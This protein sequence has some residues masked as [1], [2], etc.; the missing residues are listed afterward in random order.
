[1]K[2]KSSYGLRR[3]HYD[4]LNHW[5]VALSELAIRTD[6]QD[7][8]ELLKLAQEKFEAAYKI[9]TNDHNA[10]Y[11]WA[12]SLLQQATS[13]TE[14][15]EEFFDLAVDKFKLAN[16]VNPKD[17]S[18]L[19]SW[20]DALVKRAKRSTPKEADSF[21]SL[22]M[23]KYSAAARLN[24]NNYSTYDHWGLALLEQAKRSSG[25][26]TEKLFTQAKQRFLR[27]EKITPGKG[28]YNIACVNAL[29]GNEVQAREWL[30]KS[31]RHKTIPNRQHLES[32]SDLNSI[33]DF[34]WFNE[35]L[36]Q[37]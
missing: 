33:R 31:L 16:E 1:M 24:D 9:K 6:E 30:E 13:N 22:A 7:S 14:K 3:N 26:S 25:V 19:I 12:N 27:C 20:G 17:C 11:N 10:I 8:D 15:F 5:G 21:F 28:A 4:V 35:I 18:I 36:S 2:Y 34:M 37:I 29:Q 23:R 32:D